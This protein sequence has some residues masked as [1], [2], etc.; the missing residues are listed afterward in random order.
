MNYLNYFFVN[1]P[2]DNKPTK[3]TTKSTKKK[4]E[5]TI[6]RKTEKPITQ[7]TLHDDSSEVI[8]KIVVEKQ[9]II[10]LPNLEKLKKDIEEITNVNWNEKQIAKRASFN[11]KD[12]KE[13]FTEKTLETSPDVLLLGTKESTKPQFSSSYE[14]KRPL[15][16]M[17]TNFNTKYF[18]QNKKSRLR[19]IYLVMFTYQTMLQQ[20]YKKSKKINETNLNIM[21]KGGNTFRMIIKELIRNFEATTEKFVLNLVNDYI[22]I[23]DFDFEIISYGLTPNDFTKI[24]NISYIV[25]LRLRN[26]L[27]KN[28]IFDFF[29]YNIESIGKKLKQFYTQMKSNLKNLDSD[30]WYSDITLDYINTGDIISGKN[31]MDLKELNKK[32]Q[33]R[34]EDR[35]WS[36]LHTNKQSLKGTKRIDFAI[37]QDGSSKNKRQGTR[38]SKSG[39]IKAKDLLKRMKLDKKFV[40]LTRISRKN[41]YFLYCSHNSIVN[42]ASQI[43]PEFAISFQL[44]RIKFNYVIYYRKKINGKIYHFKDDVPGEILDLSHSYN[45]DRK[46]MKFK[47]PFNNNKYLDMYKITGFDINFYSYSLIGMLD[48]VDVIIFDEVNYKPWTETKFKKRLYRTLFLNSLM[49]FNKKTPDLTYKQ[50][51]IKLQEFVKNLKKNKFQVDFKNTQLNNMQLKLKKTYENKKGNE[52]E[53]EKYKTILFTIFDNLYRIFYSQYKKTR[54]QQLSLDNQNISSRTFSL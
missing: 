24:N 4:T 18:W 34:D 10:N 36:G 23:G 13:L 48:D 12:Y 50:K 6:T 22:K 1:N 9:T 40:N 20:I 17:A 5:I 14:D 3:P 37:I 27:I 26:Y 21:F 54:N 39:L 8:K 33:Y 29:K 51:L 16:D 38:I 11:S 35:S 19:F 43:N 2:K 42:I 45:E 32:Y 7:N 52:I 30:N 46:K 44:N 15:M 41:G 49:Y 28:D 47:Q 53:Y 25:M 31:N